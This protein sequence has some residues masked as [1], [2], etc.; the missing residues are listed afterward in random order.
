L[1]GL[2]PPTAKTNSVA[3]K[4]SAEPSAEDEEEKPAAVD[5]VLSEAQNI[6]TD[7]LH[8]LKARPT[9]AVGK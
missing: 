1:P 7:Y 8:L 2:P 5:P 6:F 9:V 3:A 4:P